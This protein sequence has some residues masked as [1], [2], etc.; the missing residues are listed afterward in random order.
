MELVYLWIEEYKNIKNQ[1]FNFSPRFECEFD[2]NTKELTINENKD[3]VSIFP[4]NINI[5][6]IVGEN[7]SG[8]S[9]VLAGIKNAFSIYK[10][11]GE[12]YS[13]G[14]N[15]KNIKA[16]FTVKE[17][18]IEILEHTIYL[19]FDLIKINPIKD[20]WSYI[21]QNI[22]QR[23]LYHFVE[24][25]LNTNSSFNIEQ[26]RK[27]FF[28][29]IIKHYNKFKSSIFTYNPNKIIFSDY[30]QSK[31]EEKELNNIIQETQEKH[32]TKEKFLVFLLINISK[33][34]NLKIPSIKNMNDLKENENFI[35]D[36]A[37]YL[38]DI[39][40]DEKDY[41]EKLNLEIDAINSF[42]EN[43]K[44]FQDKTIIS[45]NEFEKI[46]NQHE[47]AFLRLINIGF[48]SID[49]LDFKERRF[50]D[51]SYGERKFF[52]ENLMVYDDIKRKNK[53]DIL[54]VLDEPDLTLHPNWQKRYINEMVNLLSNFPEKKFHIVITSHSPFILSDIPKE[55]VIFLEKY[56]KDEDKEQKEGNCKNV[57]KNME[58]KTFG[59]NI[60]TL[61]S[62]GF[63]M[64]DGLMGE[65]AKNKINEAIDNLHEKLQSLSQKQIKSI[66]DTI[67]EPFLQIKLKQMYKEKFGLEDEIKELEKR[68]KE[69]NLKIEQLKKQKA[70]NA[71]P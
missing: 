35:I 25:N 39:K 58:L 42:F 70:E 18:T 24:S 12:Y 10:I 62:N 56:I 19:D 13:K 60:H 57:T 16:P 41:K 50:F 52:T 26:F 44:Q 21:Y 68:Q 38:F 1:G 29:L 7:G 8:K 54:I 30:I 59:A 11:N 33:L 17:N 63:F 15:I 14:F 71:K 3:Y 23:N 61:L 20:F 49:L 4:D 36:N 69:I 9:S 6:A 46:F 47:K 48:I 31:K 67:G 22:Y 2:K 5:T 65:F 34:D 37:K 28:N 40:H 45:I 66:I 53:N 32:L 43:M 55:N 64:S 27:N 51:L